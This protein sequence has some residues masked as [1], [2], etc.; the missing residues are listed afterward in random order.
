MA[1]GGWA[2]LQVQGVGLKPSDALERCKQSIV[3]GLRHLKAGLPCR[4]Q[5]V[6]KESPCR[7]DA[8]Q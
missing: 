7:G 1:A 6:H 3:E 2:R 4:G 5:P 8:F